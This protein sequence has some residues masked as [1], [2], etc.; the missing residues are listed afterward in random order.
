MSGPRYT[1]ASFSEAPM[2]RPPTIAPLIEVKPPMI[3]TGRALSTT[4]ESENC[5][6]RR[7]PQSSPA[8]SPTNPATA[9]TTAHTLGRRIPTLIAAR[10]SSATARSARPMR[11]R[12]NS[13]DS[14]TTRAAAVAAANRS[15]CDSSKPPSSSGA[16]LMASS[17]P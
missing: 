16:S 14:S 17:R 10:G 4:S 13:K 8:T 2:I 12:L 1:S 3:S 15:N 7:A 11:V 5:T 6:P 9:Q